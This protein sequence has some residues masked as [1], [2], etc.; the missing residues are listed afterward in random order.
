M[1]DPIPSGQPAKHETN[2]TVPSDHSPVTNEEIPSAKETP[3]QQHS[4]SH[5]ASDTKEA[6]GLGNGNEAEANQQQDGE[7]TVVSSSGTNKNVEGNDQERDEPEDESKYLSGYKLA[8]L[9]LGLCLTTFVIALD[10]TII[11]T[12]IPK[13]TTVFN[14]L[15]D[16][17]WYGS[18]YLLTTCSLQPSFGKVYTYFDVKYTYLFALLLFEVGSIICA[19][20]TSSPMF[21][22]GRA[23]AGAGAAALFSG[24]MTIIGY[25]VP[26]RKRAIYIAALSSMFGIASVVGPILGGALTDKVSWRWCFWI[27]LPFGAVSLA[28]VFFFFTN[29][30][31]QYSH[32]SVKDRIKKIDLLG[33]VFLICAIVSLLLALQWGG[34]TYAWKNSKVWGT[35][36]GFGLIISV[37]IAIQI[38]QK[39]EATI[40]VRV[41]KQ[42]TIL[43]SCVF[44][45]LLS[46]ALYTHIFYLPFY[47]QAIKGT[48]AEESG[49]R[50]IAYLVSV[51]VASIVIG[52]LITT[53]GKY[54][55]FMWLGSIIFTIGSGMLYTLQVNSGPS[56]WIGYQV[57][58]GIGCGASVQ[59]PFI[60]VQVVASEKD[61]PTANALVMFFNSLGG[62]I[63]LSIAQNVFI[64]GLIREVPRYAP[65]L[66][67]K[68]VVGAG[69]TYI[70]LVVPPAFLEG[71]LVAYMKSISGAFVI[72][73][74]TG[75]I[76]VFVGFGME[77]L[78]VKGKNI[79]AGGGA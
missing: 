20:A 64:N 31:R 77:R 28:V 8:I 67:P 74:A 13:I 41:F 7:K 24:G 17:G 47:F 72:S 18:S 55:P 60:A 37:F 79:V 53:I 5:V 70:R 50:T 76:A 42:R 39:D 12:A 32:M 19:A 3:V 66:D 27:N 75:G 21:I 54:A 63:S 61:M 25:S 51:T 26:L 59:I 48:T 43:V 46:M 22:V 69:A 34:Q 40:P 11:A 10:N 1:S 52:G 38:W 16:V 71:V 58:T 2:D 68:V 36:L 30:E 56:K 44:S 45:A 65:G 14:S 4:T 49:I 9:S 33:A 6:N 57:L 78:S 23:V 62:A 35:L 73:I 29:P 15:N